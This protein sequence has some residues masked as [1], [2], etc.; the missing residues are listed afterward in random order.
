[1]GNPSLS[2]VK[3]IMIGV[4]NNSKDIK[5]GEFWVN[6]LRLTDFNEDGGWAA[7]ANL[8]IALSD[9]GTLNMGGVWRLP[10][11]E[12]WINPLQNAGLMIMPNTIWLPMWN[13]GSCSQRKRK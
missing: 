7:N 8:Q 5:S 3:T 6:E 11:L 1:M 2:E 12:V 10:A 13:L 4:R 9:F